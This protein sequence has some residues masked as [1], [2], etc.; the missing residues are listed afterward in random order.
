MQYDARYT[1][2]TYSVRWSMPV[3]WEKNGRSYFAVE[4]NAPPVMAATD[5]DIE[6][7]HVYGE[8]PFTLLQQR[9]ALQWP[10][11]RGT[12]AGITGPAGRPDQ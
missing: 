9:A 1:P 6:T 11:L 5:A 7:L 4:E 2:A 8:H 10:Q 12:T 3:Y